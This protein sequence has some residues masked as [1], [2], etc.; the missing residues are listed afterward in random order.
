MKKQEPEYI[1]I[2]TILSPSGIKGKMKVD[3]NTDFPERFS[4]SSEVYINRQ[5]VTIESVEWHKG[6]VIIKVSAVNS[7]EDARKMQGQLVEIHRSQLYVL[8]K[9]QYY[10][11]E[12]IGLEAR[13]T[14]GEVLGEVI[15]IMATPGNDTYIVNGPRGEIL[16]P[17]TEDVVKSIDLD[18]GLLVIEPVDGLLSLNEKRAK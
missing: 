9:G 14:E 7:V 4:P 15:D 12:L 2:G 18:E 3:I 10:H 11:F 8:P 16:I 1:T 5:P 13:T 17:A 6:R